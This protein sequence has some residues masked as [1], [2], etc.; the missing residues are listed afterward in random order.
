M[1]RV[2]CRSYFSRDGM[3]RV[4]LNTGLTFVGADLTSSFAFYTT[5]YYKE[6]SV[7][8]NHLKLYFFSHMRVRS[9]VFS[10]PTA[11]IFIIQIGWKRKHAVGWKLCGGFVVSLSLLNLFYND[12]ISCIDSQELGHVELFFSFIQVCFLSRRGFMPLNNASNSLNGY[13]FL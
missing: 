9:L 5:P 13:E 3:L 6:K 8:F 1:C 2:R 7:L 12:P 11:G 10:S 4:C